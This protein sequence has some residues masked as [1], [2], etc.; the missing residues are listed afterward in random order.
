MT[1]PFRR[2][3]L[4]GAA[5]VLSAL[6]ANHV[7]A[8][9][10]PA[11]PIQTVQIVGIA[12][13]AGLDVDS[14][15]LPYSV[16][17]ASSKTL[18]RAQSEN[19]AGYMARNLTGVNVNEISGSPFQNDI[20]Y[21]GFRASP[22][23]GTAQGL[24]VYLDGVRVNEPFGDVV[25]WDM[26]PEAA[27][28]NVLL[29]PGSNPLYGLNTL[30][31]ALALSSKS[32]LS[33][34]GFEAN[35]S[36]SNSG[37]RRSDLAYGVSNDDNWHAFVAATL[38]DDNGWRDHSAGQLGNAFLKLGRA[39]GATEWDL[40]LLGGSSRLVGN[41]LLPSYRWQE[42]GQHNGL[43]EDNRRAAY[44]FPDQTKNRLTQ[45]TLHLVHHFDE[46]TELSGSGYLRNSRR[47]MVNGDMS[48]AYGDYVDACAQGFNPDG[49]AVDPVSCGMTRAQGAALHTASLNTTSTRQRSGGLSAQWS[50]TRARHQLALGASYDHNRVSFAQFEQAADFSAQRE[51]LADPAAEREPTSSVIG[52]ARAL[53]L[54]L[55]DTWSVTEATHVT[56]SARLNHARVSNT[57]TND[58]GQQ[59]PESFTYKKLNPA[60]G[61]AHVIGGAAAGLTVFANLAQG[62]RV[63]T[64][65]ELGC[66]DPLQPCRLPVGLQSDPFLKQVVARTI[67]AGARAQIGSASFSAA[68]Y[69]T[70][71]RDDILFLS[72]GP[73]QQGYFS[74]FERTLHQ[75]LDLSANRQF[76]PLSARLSYSYLDAVYDAS[77]Q[78]F[79][80]ARNVSVARGTR[81]AGLPRHTFKLALDWKATRALTFGG[82]LQVVSN[83]LTQGNEDGLR[84]DP[85][86]GQAPQY[87]DWRV[88]G[89]ALLNLRASYHPSPQW[90]LFGRITNVAN[91]RYET[92]GALATDMFPNGSLLQ[93]HEGAVDAGMAR[94]VAPGAPRALVAGL[95][96]RF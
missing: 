13:Q 80:G 20:T 81:I 3:R 43:Y 87:A 31:G 45:G 90:E 71:N 42:D 50:A 25:N 78:L 18:Q 27:I 53:G 73:T 10:M 22:V 55:A 36:T 77:G 56:A 37:Q 44:T 52:S 30:G 57:L 67:E 51:V 24:S 17:S 69:R 48:E 59:A 40:T 88:R 58:N 95:R 82:D 16:Q 62:N 39:Q 61:V 41:G 34:P 84:A 35:L 14:N 65:I 96:Y 6:A 21:R 26:L 72:A 79:T 33:H 1:V 5:A 68:L 46:H 7:R 76:G 11:D 75:G 49:S 64:V 60:L 23:L 28:D 86:A 12:P 2:Q 38:F 85:V 15:W 8:Q 29:V 92:Y 19:L 83:L 9:E 32:G 91:R 63:P 89:Y 54:Y 94:F 74:N 93:P 66:A 47:D 4:A 70:V